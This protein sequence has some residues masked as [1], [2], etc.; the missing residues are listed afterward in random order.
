VIYNFL[1]LIQKKETYHTSGIPG[2]APP[3][4]PAIG[5][6]VV[7]LPPLARP[8]I[9]APHRSNKKRKILRALLRERPG[10]LRRLLRRK[11]QQKIVPVE[12]PG[13]GLVKIRSGVPRYYPYI[14]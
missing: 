6:P 13:S 7:P 4:I 12:I 11:L 10:L 9:F 3:L 2:G 1:N 14:T 8:T 5:A